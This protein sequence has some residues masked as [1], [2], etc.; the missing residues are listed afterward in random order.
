MRY[1]AGRSSNVESGGNFAMPK[2]ETRGR[3]ASP[4]DALSSPTFCC[5]VAD[6]EGLE[7]F[8]MLS[9]SEALSVF[10]A[11]IESGAAISHDSTPKFDLSSRTCLMSSSGFVSRFNHLWLTVSSAA[12]AQEVGESSS[13]PLQS[14]RHDRGHLIGF[15]AEDPGRSPTPPTQSSG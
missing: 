11:A 5:P 3:T 1:A 12:A 6:P 10:S 14:R 8:P 15:R 7:R 13:S 9:G 4:P 2:A